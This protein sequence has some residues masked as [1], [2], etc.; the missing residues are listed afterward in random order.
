MRGGADERQP[1]AY[2]EMWGD[3]GRCG[4]VQT[5]GSPPPVES[6][7]LQTVPLGSRAAAGAFPNTVPLVPS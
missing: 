4:E 5:S 3:V 1:A 6:R 2:G 7:K